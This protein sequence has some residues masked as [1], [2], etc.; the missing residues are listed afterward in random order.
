MINR[1]ASDKLMHFCSGVHGSRFLRLVF[2]PPL[3]HASWTSF[4]QPKLGV[5]HKKK[6]PEEIPGLR[7]FG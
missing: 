2:S 5:R 3:V 6:G 7:H 1:Q 4:V